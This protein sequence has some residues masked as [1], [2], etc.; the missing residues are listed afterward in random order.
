MGGVYGPLGEVAAAREDTPSLAKM[1]PRC[2]WT[3][4][5]DIHDILGNDDHVVVLGALRKLIA[6]HASR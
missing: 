1:L 5:V 3:A 2:R 4:L 6:D